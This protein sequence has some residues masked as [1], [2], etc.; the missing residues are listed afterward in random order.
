LRLEAKVLLSEFSFPCSLVNGTTK[1]RVAIPPLHAGGICRSPSDAYAV[2]RAARSLGSADASTGRQVLDQQ[3]RAN[4]SWV[5]GDSG[6]AGLKGSKAMGIQSSYIQSD[7]TYSQIG[8]V[9]ARTGSYVNVTNCG[10]Y[11]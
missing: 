5:G 6:G 10:N 4:Y 1:G 11:C 9:Q 7:A 2:A 8:H 3:V